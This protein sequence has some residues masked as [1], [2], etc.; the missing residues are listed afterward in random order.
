MLSG[1]EAAAAVVIDAVV[2]QLP[3]A[4]GHE[5][6]AREDSFVAGLLDYP[7]YTRPVAYNTSSMA[8]SRSASGV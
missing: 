1:G 8:R 5:D 6:S 2:R 7:H 4:L 3:G